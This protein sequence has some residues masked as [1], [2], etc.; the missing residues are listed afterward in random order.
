[1]CATGVYLDVESASFDLEA[2]FAI[3]SRDFDVTRK[4]VDEFVIRL[5]E[6]GDDNLTIQYWATGDRF[7]QLLFNDFFDQLPKGPVRYL[8]PDQVRL[9]CDWHIRVVSARPWHVYGVNNPFYREFRETNYWQDFRLANS[10][11]ET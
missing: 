11:L 1:M 6:K 10:K 7:S 3:L 2:Y 8:T 5:A 4:C 9:I